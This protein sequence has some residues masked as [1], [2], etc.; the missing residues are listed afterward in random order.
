MTIM[1][2]IKKGMIELKNENIE[3][4]KMKSR[5]LMQYILNKPR[6]YII[7]NDMEEINQ[8]KEKEYFNLIK[9]MRE[10]VPLEH[11]THQKEFMKLN[12][13]VNENVLIPRQDTEI[14]IS[15]HINGK[16]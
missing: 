9:R 12:F 6:Q 15:N 2:A 14:I 7:V 16:K 10:G 4:P 13:F 8:N 5:L 11:I 1:E 3:S